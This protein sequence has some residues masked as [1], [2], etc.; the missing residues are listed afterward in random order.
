VSPKACLLFPCRSISYSHSIHLLPILSSRVV[1][2]HCLEPKGYIG[3]TSAFSVHLAGL[4]IVVVIYH[5]TSPQ[6]EY[7]HLYRIEKPNI[8]CTSYPF[9]GVVL[10]SV[11]WILQRVE[12]ANIFTLYE[13]GRLERCKKDGDLILDQSLWMNHI[14]VCW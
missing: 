9:I 8:R 2:D 3:K 11:S 10:R 1:P 7:L 12:D 14:G 5:S 4:L 13:I 6:P